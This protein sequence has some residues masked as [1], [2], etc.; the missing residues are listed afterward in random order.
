MKRATLAAAALCAAGWL[1]ACQYAPDFV[2]GQ[3]ECSLE[4]G[5]PG[6]FVCVVTDGGDQ[7]VCVTTTDGGGSGLGGLGGASASGGHGGAGGGGGAGTG[8]KG[9]SGGS[10]G[11]AGGSGTGGGGPGT[12]GSG[13]HGGSGGSGTGGG[14]GGAGAGGASDAGTCP[15][16]CTL[17]SHRCAGGLLETCA[18]TNGCPA[19]SSGTGC[20]G[21]ATCTEN[22]SG[23]DASCVCNA[24]PAGCNGQ[25]GSYCDT[26][27]L[28]LETCLSDTGCLYLQSP[29]TTCPSGKP[30][31]VTGGQASC[32]CPAPPAACMGVTGPTCASDGSAQFVT[33]SRDS[34]TQ[35]LVTGQTTACKGAQKCTGLPGAAQCTC[36]MAPTT[37]QGF[38]NGT[39]CSSN[40]VYSCATDVGGCVSATLMSSCD[41]GKPCG[42]TQGSTAACMCQNPA[43]P[44]DCTATQNSGAHC[45]GSTLIKCTTNTDGCTSESTTAC[46]TT[47]ACVHAYPS[48][49]CVSQTDYGWPTDTG[50]GTES[51]T[52][53]YLSGVPVTVAATSTLQRF[54]VVSHGGGGTDQI[55][56]ALYASDVNGNPTTRVASM[57]AT[58]LAVGTNEYAATPSS[59]T[60]SANATYWIMAAT[61]A[62]VTVGGG[63]SQSVTLDYIVYTFGNPLPSP[64]PTTY[65]TSPINPPPTYYI[66]TLPQ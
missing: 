8:G 45:S 54:G 66:V 62:T 24:A 48:A 41:A 6:G 21:H 25:V 50:S 30:C 57:V 32:S 42:G 33:C 10:G 20:G 15:T 61:N 38:G 37:C 47:G 58:A 65:A 22:A 4:L 5:C 12:A 63:P 40:D 43:S 14:S 60:L 2:S 19:W 44:S 9:G 64:W 1:T 55:V 18:L 13:G 52:T 51:A 59:V 39:V 7:G 36:P 49:I 29:A 56:M 46:P 26:D 11:A 27:N 53:G 28:T 31:T 16:V 23:T 34:T 17:S 35:C 3:T